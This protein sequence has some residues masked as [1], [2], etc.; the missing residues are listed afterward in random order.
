MGLYSDKALSEG[1]TTLAGIV[2]RI[3]KE[4]TALAPLQGEGGVVAPPVR[5]YSA[6]TVPEHIPADVD[7]RGEYLRV[8]P[9]HC[10]REV[11]RGPSPKTEEWS[12]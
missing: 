4:R 5:K 9:H 1:T 6:G 12:I 11:L 2:E 8:R 7:C 3:M 10:T